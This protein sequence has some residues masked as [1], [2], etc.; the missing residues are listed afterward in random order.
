VEA[1][2]ITLNPEES[3]KEYDHIMTLL[4]RPDLRNIWNYQLVEC[5]PQKS[6]QSGVYTTQKKP[7]MALYSYGP[8]KEE[9]VAQKFNEQ[10]QPIAN[11][12]KTRVQAGEFHWNGK[13]EGR[14]FETTIFGGGSKGLAV[15]EGELTPESIFLQQQIERRLDHNTKSVD[16]P[17]M[18]M[19]EV[20]IAEQS[21]APILKAYL[22]REIVDLMKLE[23]SSWGVFLSNQLLKDYDSLLSKVKI[24]IRPT[25][26]MDKKANASLD[27]SLAQF[28]RDIGKRDYFPEAK[29][30]LGVLQSLQ[31][32]EFSYLGHVDLQ[33]K[34]RF[35]RV[36]PVLYWGISQV[37]G[38]YKLTKASNGSLVAYSPLVGTNPKIEEILSRN[39]NDAKVANGKF[40]GV[41]EFIPVDF[42]N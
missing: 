12:V 21:I 41:E 25:D 4:S 23:P 17:L 33:N 7:M 3:R 38:A 20:V 35:N 1:G 13:V 18:E 19:L 27:K 30:T 28:Y 42:S 40:G 31:K 10:G 36:K 11:P 32:V 15:E 22:H 34:A 9:E 24:R 6:N 2:E 8:V 29:F 26:W 37:D 5:S 39:Y 14:E 16:S